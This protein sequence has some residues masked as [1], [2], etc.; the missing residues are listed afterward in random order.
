MAR[1][2]LLAATQVSRSLLG[3]FHKYQ[4]HTNTIDALHEALDRGAR[5]HPHLAY[6]ADTWHSQLDRLR[7]DSPNITIH[8]SEQ[9]LENE[10]KP[11]A[12]QLRTYGS[13]KD[14]IET[15]FGERPTSSPSDEPEVQEFLALLKEK[16][17]NRYKAECFFRWDLA[18]TEAAH[19]GWFFIFDTLTLKPGH[20]QSF[21][22]NPTKSF[23]QYIVKTKR[24]ISKVIYGSQRWPGKSEDFHKYF[25][26]VERGAKT[27]RLHIHCLHM[28]KE[29]PWGSS[30]PNVL[31]PR[32]RRTYREIN[33]M[34]GYW[35]DGIS[36][37]IAVR[38]HPADAYGK[39]NWVWP[40]QAT[41]SGII[42]PHPIGTV[43]LLANYMGKYLGKA[44]GDQ[45]WHK[46]GIRRVRQTNR[47]GETT[48]LHWTRKQTLTR[49]LAILATPDLPLIRLRNRPVTTT[50]LKKAIA[51]EI[52]NRLNP[53]R[54]CPHFLGVPSQTSF[55][56][57]WL[58]N[59]NKG[60]P[61]PPPTTRERPVLPNTGATAREF[62]N[63]TATSEIQSELE[64]LACEL[65]GPAPPSPLRI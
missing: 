13:G 8:T 43:V 57:S 65:F 6:R 41:K 29:L 34:K 11:R 10:Y 28:C 32:G 9:A 55:V 39:R 7:L 33:A 24:N 3:S 53:T 40:D 2:N 52:M 45:S 42:K 22:D 21:L 64:E 1:L 35:N 4:R 25:A 36:M 16:Q 12:K 5:T 61:P 26:V 30:D 20:Y 23:N 37:P 47:L 62:W 44:L 38:L 50:M 60:D 58:R 51:R 49:L 63:A 56:I 46:M 15:V 14:L 19:A 31:R 59:R 54:I 18:L 27:G 17:I 48:L